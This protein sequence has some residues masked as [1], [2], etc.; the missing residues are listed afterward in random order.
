[1]PSSRWRGYISWKNAGQGGPNRLYANSRRNQIDMRFAK[2]FRFDGHRLD[3]G[4]DVQNLLNS[5]YGT[6]YDASY[7]TLG[8]PA[9]ATFASPTSVV[10]PRFMRLNF[11]YDF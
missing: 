7:G 1:M 8:S 5:S 2:I 11:T 4:V 6:V 9:S 10:T 3:V